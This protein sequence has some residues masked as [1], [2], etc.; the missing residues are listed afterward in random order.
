MNNFL[1][2][3]YV[4]NNENISDSQF[5]NEAYEIYIIFILKYTI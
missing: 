4:K 3:P 2:R 1:V 5:D